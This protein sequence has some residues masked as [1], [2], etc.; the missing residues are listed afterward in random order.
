MPF[1]ARRL[2]AVTL[3]VLASAHSLAA[4][5]TPS[6]AHR[7]AWWEAGAAA[8]GVGLL[9]AVDGRMHH[10]M[11]RN[12]DE[13]EWEPLA[14]TF[15]RMGEPAILVGVPLALMAS[16]AIAGDGGR[17]V[18]SQGKRALATA[19]GAMPQLRTISSRIRRFVALSS[20]IKT[21]MP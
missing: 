10:L 8:V 2:A 12:Y 15:R 21:R 1:Q 19:A 13:G 18:V 14:S 7:I 4:Q 17:G 16:G 3:A 20:T 6:T 11:Q 9:Y 5:G